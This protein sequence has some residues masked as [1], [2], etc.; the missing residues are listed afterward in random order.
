MMM[1]TSDKDNDHLGQESGTGGSV[2][3]EALC[4]KS[5]GP[6]FKT[7]GGEWI[8]TV[9]NPSSRTGFRGLLGL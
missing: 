8:F 9:P 7:R 6:W 2:V 1:M 5:E 4:Y 3:D